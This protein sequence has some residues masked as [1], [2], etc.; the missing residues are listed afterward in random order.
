M[1]E[2]IYKGMMIKPPIRTY[3]DGRDKADAAIRKMYRAGPQTP[4]AVDVYEQP[5][6]ANRLSVT[7]IKKAL[8]RENG[9]GGTEVDIDAIED[10][11]KGWNIPS[12]RWNS[13]TKRERAE[14]V[15][16]ID[17]RGAPK[18]SNSSW[19]DNHANTGA[20]N[21]WREHGQLPT[22]TATTVGSQPIGAP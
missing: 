13:M 19:D 22:L 17:P 9:I 8:R 4:D 6:V 2:Y 12:A 7:N 18:S 3:P 10:L 16:K 21:D 14:L 11:H 5:E 20:G 1:S 15:R